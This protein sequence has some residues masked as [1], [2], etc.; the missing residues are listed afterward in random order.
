MARISTMTTSPAAETA[1][2]VN[3]P[4]MLAATV[5][6]ARIK[7][8]TSIITAARGDFIAPV[9]DMELALLVTLN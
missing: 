5:R 2:L 9:M 6:P 8:I 7:V 1:A 4:L 3:A